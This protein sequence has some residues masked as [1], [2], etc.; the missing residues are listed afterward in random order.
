[1]SQLRGTALALEGFVKVNFD[2]L[3]I[4]STRRFDYVRSMAT[5]A[6]AICGAKS[7]DDEPPQ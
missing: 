4:V 7:T 2:K 5:A 1:M 6:L 3:L